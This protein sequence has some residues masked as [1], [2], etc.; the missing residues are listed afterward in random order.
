MRTLPF[1]ASL[2][3]VLLAACAQTGTPPDP[4]PGMDVRSPR[5]VRLYYNPPRC[6]FRDVGLVRARSYRE[7]REQAFG[8]HAHG[9]IIDRLSG[10]TPTNSRQPAAYEGAAIQF[11][12]TDCQS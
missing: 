10:R 4:A 8:L 1:R 9:V 6:A 11:T 5:Y 7:L 3:A 12:R 2:L